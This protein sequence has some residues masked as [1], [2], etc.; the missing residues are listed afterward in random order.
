ML[1][2]RGRTGS[3]RVGWKVA[4]FLVLCAASVTAATV[5][6]G[7]FAPPWASKDGQAWPVVAL[8]A[9]FILGSTRLCLRMEGRRAVSF[10][11]RFTHLAIGLASGV[12][13]VGLLAWA[14]MLAGVL[15][16]QPNRG[17]SASL[18]LSGTAYFCCAV[19]V[20]ELVFRGYA[21]QRLAE[22]VGSRAAVALLAA[23]FGG[24]HL[25]TLGTSPS[26]KAGGADLLW[27]AAGP[28]IGAIVFGVAALRTGGIALPVGLH[29]GWNWT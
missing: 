15:Y 16:W 6:V 10:R 9:L 25:L 19:L 11:P 2:I 20:E 26:V 23:A 4:G 21:L 3:V 8:A 14:L 13:L 1:I 29:L 22:G 24:Y 27:V 17:F 5:L 28:A 12:A 18:M 7:M